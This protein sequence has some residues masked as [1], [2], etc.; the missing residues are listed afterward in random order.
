MDKNDFFNLS[1]QFDAY[2][3]LVDKDKEEQ[4]KQFIN[5]LMTAGRF[6]GVS[7]AEL[8]AVVPSRLQIKPDTSD[9]KPTIEE[10]FQSQDLSSPTFHRQGKRVAGMYGH[11]QHRSSRT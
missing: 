6:F 2:E 5:G 10:H 11:K 9:E 3:Q 8:R 4:A 1:S 7:Y